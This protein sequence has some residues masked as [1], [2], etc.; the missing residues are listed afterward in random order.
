VKSEKNSTSLIEMHVKRL[1]SKKACQRNAQ[2]PDQ[3]K[4][5][6]KRV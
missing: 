2:A 4:E 6:Y 1:K 5:H 3:T